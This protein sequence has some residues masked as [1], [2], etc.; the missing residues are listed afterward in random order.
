MMGGMVQARSV[1]NNANN[2]QIYVVSA[3]DFHGE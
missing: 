1:N 3:V 2:T